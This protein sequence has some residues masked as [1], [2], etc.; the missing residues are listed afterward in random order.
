MSIHSAQT[1]NFGERLSTVT[2]GR[3]KFGMFCSYVCCYLLPFPN[4]SK[5][6]H[7]TE[8]RRTPD[9]HVLGNRAD[10]HLR[11]RIKFLI[12]HIHLPRNVCTLI[13]LVPRFKRI[14]FKFIFQNENP[15]NECNFKLLLSASE[16]KRLVLHDVRTAPGSAVAS[17][18]GHSSWVLSAD[19]SPDG[20][21]GLSG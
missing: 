14:F 5:L 2:S 20:R 19:I 16:D 6:T 4:Y 18:S 15:A 11:R 12:F 1:D 13:G 3:N 7:S 17:F 9:C 10:L 8:P 21:L